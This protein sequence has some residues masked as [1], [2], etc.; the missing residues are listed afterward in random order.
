MSDIE[1]STPDHVGAVQ[2][3]CSDEGS[4]PDVGLLLRISPTQM[5]WAGE[6]TRD[7]WEDA[8]PDAAALGSDLGWWC[9]LYGD[10]DTRVLGRFTNQDDAQ[11]LIEALAAALT[12][13]PPT[14]SN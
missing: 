4:G 10:K 13:P 1:V 3:H 14:R 8:G 12:R 2:W 7:R 9:I 5:L 11:H 6:I